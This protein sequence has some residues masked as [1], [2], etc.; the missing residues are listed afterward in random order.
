MFF[1]LAKKKYSIDC[2]V[3]ATH[4]IWIKKKIVFQTSSFSV[5]SWQ[6][7][8]IQ[9][10]AIFHKKSQ[11]NENWLINPVLFILF[12]TILFTWSNSIYYET[13][14]AKNKISRWLSSTQQKRKEYSHPYRDV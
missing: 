1:F 13:E 11:F 9:Y 3:Q 4:W 12:F 14:L 10:Y 2:T 7:Y 6:N 8:K 5:Q